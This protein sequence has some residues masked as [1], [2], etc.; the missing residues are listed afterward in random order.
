[1]DCFKYLGLTALVDEGVEAGEV[2]GKRS[3]KEYWLESE[4]YLN[5]GVEV[6]SKVYMGQW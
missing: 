1:M 3:R 5:I 6:A 2:Q 4:R